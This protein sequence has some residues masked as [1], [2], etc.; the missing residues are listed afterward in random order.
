MPE[1]LTNDRRTNSWSETASAKASGG[2]ATSTDAGASRDAGASTDARA[3]T[4]ARAHA[5]P[6]DNAPVS[7]KDSRIEELERHVAG[8]RKRVEKLGG[9][10]MRAEY[11]VLHLT[12][13]VRRSREAFG[14]LAGFQRKIGAAAS[15]GALYDVALKSII[16]ELWMKRAVVL[17]YVEE[18]QVLRP[19]GALGY[20]GDQRPAAIPVGDVDR[21]EWTSASLV[22]GNSEQTAW[23]ERVTSALS[24]PFFT[25]VPSVVDEGRETILVAGTL[26]EDSA[27]EPRLTDHDLGLLV[28]VGAIL[29]VGRMNLLARARLRLQVRYE[30]LLHRIS[31]VLLK[32][33]DAPTSHFDDV[34]RRV[35]RAWS[36]DRVRLI[37]RGTGANLSSVRHEWTTRGTEAAGEGSPHP[38]EFASEWREAMA[39]G[40]TIR[41][42]DTKVLPSDDSAALREQGI[43]SLLLLPVTVNE[44]V[45]AWM[46]F[47][48]CSRRGAWG[49]EDIKILEVIT[50]L[51]ARAIGRQTDLEERAHLEAEYN[52]AKKMEAVGQLAGGVAHDFNNLLTTIQGYAQLLMSR[53]PEEYR[54]SGGLKEIVMASERAAGLTR[55]LLTFSRKDTTHTSAVNLNESIEEMMKLLHRM[56]GDG[57][58]VELD[59]AKGL[60]ITTGDKQQLSQIIMNLAINARDAMS[61]E[62][63]LKI[64]TREYD[65]IGPLAQRFTIPGVE[66]CQVI[67]VSDTGTGMDKE[68]QERIFEPFF[69]TKEAGKGTGL[70]LSIVFGVIRRHGG[71]VDIES[72][73]GQGTTFSVYL[74]VKTPEAGE[75]TASDA[76]EAMHGHETI[77][78]VED[79]DNVR[80]LIVSVLSENGYNVITATNGREALERMEE[81][82]DE[83]ALLLTDVVMPEMNGRELWDSFSD[84]GYDIPLII[85]S[86]YPKGEEE[87][88]F[89]DQAST[90]LQKPFGPREIAE[91][92]RHTLDADRAGRAGRTIPGHPAMPG[93]PTIPDRPGIN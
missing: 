72:R 2:A 35:G 84:R 75:K 59:L 28:S 29:W 38:L 45:V 3:S 63:N 4:Y 33:Y 73:L 39:A 25:W 48:Q 62:G 83:V 19:V 18:E 50:S 57:V 74:P 13:E 64:S 27:Q 55:Q 36:F 46:S 69:T 34:I 24:L 37:D 10:S 43:R 77:L 1:D 42:D 15:I 9:E 81:S 58:K 17:E 76:L 41:I 52:H 6:C 67:E 53:L 32:D 20:Q 90:Y 70:G 86:G 22:N 82:A 80:G 44:A 88:G 71:F 5:A 60:S 11:K 91:A 78:L 12:Q 92:V 7:D 23:V 65:N 56:L 87:G 54:E 49:N 30:A 89:L 21:E 16:A 31:E 93:H 40:Q 8:L 26:A 47:E 66:R 85:M 68:T 51:I 61:G 79:D 14:F